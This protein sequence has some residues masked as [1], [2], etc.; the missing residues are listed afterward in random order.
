MEVKLVRAPT[1]CQ[2]GHV[3]NGLVRLFFA[4]SIVDSVF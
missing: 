1:L 4:G 2:S 3:N